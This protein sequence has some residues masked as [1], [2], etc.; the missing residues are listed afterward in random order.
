MDVNWDT[1]WRIFGMQNLGHQKII[2]DTKM[3]DAGIPMGHQ[4]KILIQ[5]LITMS[6]YAQNFLNRWYFL[7]A[8][9]YLL[10][11][12]DIRKI[13]KTGKHSCSEIN[14]QL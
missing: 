12:P 3:P 5:G 10:K 11:N 6:S 13:R 9:G 8:V 7:V 1:A 4:L 2:R 14:G